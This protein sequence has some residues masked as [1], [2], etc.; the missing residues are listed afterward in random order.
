MRAWMLFLSLAFTAIGCR[1]AEPVAVVAPAQEEETG[2][3]EFTR[4]IETYESP[5]R[6]IWQKPDLVIEQF[7]DIRGKVLA[8]LGA[9][10]G[11]FSRRLAYV[12][13]K[14][15]AIDI[16]PT[17]IRW[18]EDQRD[19][20]PP[21]LRERLTIR[22]ARPDDPGLAAGEVDHVLLVNTYSYIRD[23]VAYFTRLKEAIRP[24]GTVLVIDFKK[25]ETPFGPDIEGRLDEQQVIDEF[26]AA[27]YSVVR[28][29][30]QSL[31]YQY[32]ITFRRD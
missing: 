25:K 1:P 24:G 3:D 2:G 17:A 8:D 4:E 6:V 26:Q 21:E 23:R 15:I 28:V 31:D 13:A 20:F 5:D 10:T 19:R 16:D 29:D 11:Y 22:L 7:G 12:G 30:D 14:V 32:M 9:G 18:M 27:G